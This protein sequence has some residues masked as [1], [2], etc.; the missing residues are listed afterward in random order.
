MAAAA[1]MM[2]VAQLIQAAAAVQ[3]KEII[4]AVQEL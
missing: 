3:V 2:Q 1:T 4:R